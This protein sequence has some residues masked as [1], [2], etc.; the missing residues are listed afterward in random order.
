MKGSTPK[1]PW[2]LAHLLLLVVGAAIISYA[3]TLP[4]EA[5]P[6]A[7]SAVHATVL[8]N[9]APDADR[10]SASATAPQNISASDQYARSRGWRDWNEYIAHRPANKMGQR[11]HDEPI[12]QARAIES[13]PAAAPGPK[14]TPEL[15]AT[16]PAPVREPAGVSDPATDNDI[17]RPTHRDRRWDDRYAYVT[18]PCC[19]DSAPI[20]RPVASVPA[21]GSIPLLLAGAVGLVIARRVRR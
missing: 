5:P 20:D 15:R 11:E 2:Y 14:A 9:A 4:A 10:V 8:P 6:S 7:P 12:G 3:L 17:S 18:R 16:S 21:P 19:S 13:L 1:Y